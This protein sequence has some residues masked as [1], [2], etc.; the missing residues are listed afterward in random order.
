MDYLLGGI[1]C[2][3]ALNIIAI[4]MM[5]EISRKFSDEIAHLDANLALAIQNV[6]KESGLGGI[7]PINPIQ[8]AIAQMFTQQFQNKTKIEPALTVLRKE[9]GKFFNND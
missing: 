5:F 7:E 6:L 3:I 1:I 9:D 8:Q 2:L 4:K